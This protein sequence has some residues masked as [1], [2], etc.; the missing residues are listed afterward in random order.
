MGQLPDL[1]QARRRL[2]LA[3]KPIAHDRWV[4]G[5]L[6]GGCLQ[7]IAASE[8]SRRFVQGR[9]LAPLSRQALCE[10]EPMVINSVFFSDGGWGD[11]GT[12]GR[13][14]RKRRET[15]DAA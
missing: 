14:C 5:Y 15:S 9:P 12:N 3:L 4:L 10:K 2:G 6:R 1:Q 11:N 13:P 7:P 8:V